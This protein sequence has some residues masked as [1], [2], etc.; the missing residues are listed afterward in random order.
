MMTMVRSRTAPGKAEDAN[1]E[2][3]RQ[4]LE[5]V[6]KELGAADE[7]SPYDSAAPDGL[8]PAGD[9]GDNP[10]QTTPPVG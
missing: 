3:R 10:G 7:S 9:Q 2:R 1:A 8:D 6:D 4:W 5:R